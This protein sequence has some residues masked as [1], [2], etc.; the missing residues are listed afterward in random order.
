[1]AMHYYVS[2][3]YVFFNAYEDVYPFKQ[4]AAKKADQLGMLIVV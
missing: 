1:M 3:N 4:E 2:L